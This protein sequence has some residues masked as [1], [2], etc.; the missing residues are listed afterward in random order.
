MST[1]NRTAHGLVAGQRVTF[2]S[3]VPS[4]G[5]GVD[6]DYV[7]YVISAGLTANA[8]QI[9][10]NEEGTP[11]TILLPITSANIIVV[12]ETDT[13]DTYNPTYAQITDPADAQAPPTTPPTP[14][15]PTVGSAIVSGIVRLQITLNDTAQAKVR[16][17]EVQITHKFD[18]SGNPDWSTGGT[19]IT[20]PEGSTLASMPALGNTSYAVR[21]SCTDVFGLVSAFSAVTLHTTIVGSDALAAAEAALAND[22]SDGIITETKI[23][24][25]SITTPKLKALAVTASKLEATLLLASLI[26]TA[27]AGSRRVEFDNTGIR[28]YDIV[29]G[30]DVLIVNIPTN[31]DPVYVKGAIQASSLISEVAATFY[32]TNTLPGSSATTLANGISA[33]T[34]APSLTANVD[35]TNLGDKIGT[36]TPASAMGLTYDS[37]GNGGLGS[38]WVACDPA[39]GYVAYEFSASGGAFIRRIAATGSTS[40][41]T[42]TIGSTSHV[43]DSAQSIAGSTNSHIAT[44]ITIPSGVTSPKVT[45]VSVYA[46]GVGGSCDLRNALWNTSGTNLG[47]SGTYTAASASF[48]N[49]NSIH[50]DKSV[51]TISVTAGTTYWAGFRRMNTSDTVQFDR[52]DGSGKT[53]KSADGTTANGT[54]WGTLNS[55]SKINVYVTYQYTVDTRLE[56]AP[57]IG[58]CT[59]GSFIYTLDTNGVIWKYDRTTLA[60]VANSGVQTAISGAKANAGLFYDDTAGEL[61]I[62]TFTGTGAGVFPKFVRVT[63]STLAVSSTVYSASAGTTF[64]GTTDT[65]RGGVRRNDALNASA[66]TYW[67]ATTSAVYGYTFSGTAATQTANRDFGQATTVGDGLTF[68]T[69]LGIFRG[70]DNAS[71][72]KVWKFTDWDFTTDSTTFWCGYSWLDDANTI[73]TGATAAAATDLVTKTSHGLV[74]DDR[75]RFTTLTGGTGLSLGVDYFVLASGLTANDFKVATSKG[76][77]AIDIT[78]NYTTVQYRVIYETAVGPRRSITI[79]RR[80]RLFVTNAPIPVGGAGDPNKVTVWGIQNATDPGAGNFWQYDS[81]TGTGAYLNLNVTTGPHD[82]LGK[83]FPAGTPASLSDAGAHWQLKGDGTVTFDTTVTPGGKPP[84]VNVYTA[85][86][87]N[88]WTKPTGVAFIV[89]EVVGAGGAGGGCAATAAGEQASGAGGGS[90]GYAR[91]VFTAA[92]LTQASYTATVGTGGTAGAA[93]NNAGNAGGNTTFSGTGITTVQG[94]GGSGGSGGANVGTAASAVADGGAGGTASGGDINITGGA[95]GSSG[96]FA[97]IRS[98]TGFGGSSPLSSN[99]KATTAGGNGAAGNTYGGGGA[100]GVNT[101]SSAA[102]TG[103]AGANGAVIVT[104]FYGA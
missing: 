10:E 7:Y 2:S 9:S 36:Q 39:T 8:F 74:A 50:Y 30:A 88:P 96:A 72:T 37:A 54:G 91:K 34:N 87:A 28:L 33:P 53:I 102:R 67:I 73:V 49:G 42:D 84:V 29:S 90:G 75:I 16:N 60:W 23:A 18:G 1:I 45:K 83:A 71:L 51:G 68:D 44:P 13:S 35:Y 98:A 43:S 63:P 32:G 11:V 41:V 48:N 40:T 17:W 85:T 55:A 56:T 69:A 31:G 12:P 81:R 62:T 89:V 26:M 77:A 80:E 79:R 103:G 20:M 66:A 101:Q 24:D 104:E 86:G 25:D 27:P 76:G 97:G 6:P 64:N 100:G 78:V 22:V 46:A 52:D 95:G 4:S 61:I 19:K 82:G 15:A 21:V 65:V 38:F 92:Q 93:G 99:A 70:F 94:N 3:I 58:V 5:T 57:M 14:T 59:D 47:E